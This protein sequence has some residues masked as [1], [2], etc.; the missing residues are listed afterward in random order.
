[1][2]P[3]PRRS[4][5][6]TPGQSVEH[7]ALTPSTLPGATPNGGRRIHPLATLA[8]VCISALI[9]NIDNTIL[10]VALP[11]LVRDLNATSIQLQWIVDSYAMVFAGLLLAGGSL[12]DRFGRKRFFLIGLT[13]FAVGSIGAALSGS[14][15]PLIACR[16]IMGAGAAFTIPASLSIIN[17]L[18]RDPGERA[19]A[20]GI[21]AGTVGLG[22]AIGPIAGGLLLSRFW[23]GS[24]FLVNVPIVV[25]GFIGALAYVTDSKNP[26]ALAPDPVGSVLSIA[27]L[28]LLLWAIVEAPTQG[29]T[30][31]AVVAVG[32]TSFL[33]LGC[34]I[35][36]EAHT[37]H[38]ML[39][40]GFFRDRR[41]SIALA[42]E[43]LGLFGLMGA[44][45]MQT[46][47]LQFELGYSPLDAGLRIMPIAL[48]LLVSAAV[49]RIMAR[50]I[51]IKLTV[52]AGLAA[53]AAGLWQA[54]AV[55]TVSAT[56]GDVVPSLLLIGLG[57]G[58]L[59]S[60]AT[61]S[62]VG[63]VPQGDSGVG[64]AT[65]SVALQ[66]GGAL[67][68]AVIG[69]VMLTRYQDHMNAALTGQHVPAAINQIIL[70]SLGGAL[71]VASTVGG[72]TGL[73]LSH[74]ARSAFMS[75]IGLS[76]AVGAAVAL[77]GVLLVVVALPSRAQSHS[78]D[79]ED[80]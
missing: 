50:L 52:A 64:S 30:S 14:V 69:S 41:F 46:Q 8:V 27:G 25:V 10:N 26:N 44:L 22:I 32:L 4:M 62:V 17:D 38:P 66:V 36:W 47:Y 11:T 45:F 63:S 80:D 56:Y 58:L 61:N 15:D 24:I 40:L 37:D 34:F 33:V 60:T 35:A 48:M 49:S 68:V 65:N 21:W 70:G 73:L 28:G 43:S 3:T 6:S 54:S 31:T 39:K 5:P 72:N 16:A 9:I 71:A 12:A 7:S 53:I 18:F 77:G 42:A 13:I 55:S 23:W 19:R 67:G 20:I 59:L 79:P 76:L 51:G 29:W 74:A 57:A 1:M 78:T 2:A 75:G